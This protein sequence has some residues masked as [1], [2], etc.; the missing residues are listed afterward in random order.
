MPDEEQTQQEP[1]E[2]EIISIN[3]DTEITGEP[4]FITEEHISR[5]RTMFGLFEANAEVIVNNVIN[6]LIANMD[7]IINDTFVDLSDKLAEALTEADIDAIIEEEVGENASEEEKK[8]KKR[9]FIKVEAE[10][11]LS[12]N[13]NKII[14]G[15]T[16]NALSRATTTGINSYTLDLMGTATIKRGNVTVTIKNFKQLTD[17]RETTSMLLD[18]LEME[19]TARPLTSGAVS[20]P[21]SAYMEMRGLKDKKEAR[22]QVKAD[23]ETLY[24]AS[25]DT[26]QKIKGKNENFRDTRI[27][28]DKGIENGIIKAT[29]APKFMEILKASQTMYYPPFLQ[30]IKPQKNPASYYIGRKIAEHKNMHYFKESADIIG[31][32]TL[33]KEAPTIPSYEEVKNSDRAFNR[34]IIS[35]LENALDAIVSTEGSD[36]SGWEY[37]HSKG[38]PLT[39]EELDE[40]FTEN[41]DTFSKLYIKIHW[42]YYPERQQKEIERKPSKKKSYK[43]KA[44]AKT[45]T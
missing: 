10:K 16:T 17:Y 40:G 22:K 1:N 38:A 21:L 14:Q 30:K 15:A 26:V 19:Y 34:R 28:S 20:L 27:I 43:K 7:T 24:Q 9:E 23:L 2:A 37:C 41:Y 11:I 33:L 3:F 18:A 32:K 12:E 35:K 25:I 42:R 4:E 31:V 39:K 13:K 36:I 44:P 29:F 6:S 5:V 8:N 45:D